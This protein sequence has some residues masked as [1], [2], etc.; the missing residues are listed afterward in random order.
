MKFRL[1]A[2]F[3]VTILTGCSQLGKV[4]GSLTRSTEG[5]DVARTLQF[6]NYRFR[7]GAAFK[8]AQ[9]GAIGVKRTAG[10]NIFEIK[11]IPQL[12]SLA[13]SRSA[14]FVKTQSSD[15]KLIGDLSLT[16]IEQMNAKVGGSQTGSRYESGIYTIYF[17][18][19][20]FE[21]VEQ[22]N[23]KE[24]EGVRE[25]LRRSPDF[26]IVTAVVKVNSH[27]LL[28]KNGTTI[29]VKALSTL[30]D[31][32]KAEADTTQT[33]KGEAKT[34]TITD[35]KNGN[36]LGL[37]IANGGTYAYE[38]SRVLW[39]RD[40]GMIVDLLVDLPGRWYVPFD[41]VNHNLDGVTHDPRKIGK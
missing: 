4:E 6:Q 14:S 18:P 34:V 16:E 13:L 32:G 40:S 39:D 2:L 26:R 27:S 20:V 33:P 12:E 5:G 1:L 41:H 38:V 35:T 22:L 30:S 23:A 15:Y 7:T 21:L 37:Q 28:V 3:L 8:A 17:L 29:N 11:R 9:L 31:E 10:P 24:N 19:N 25:Y 36:P